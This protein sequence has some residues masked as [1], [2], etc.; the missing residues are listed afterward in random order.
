MAVGDDRPVRVRGPAGRDQPQHRPRASQRRR[1]LDETTS[2][3]GASPASSA[4]ADGIRRLGARPR[5]SSCASTQAAARSGGG[6][7]AGADARPAGAVPPHP[8]RV[9]AA[10]TRVCDSQRFIMGPEVEGMERETGRLP[11]RRPRGRR[12][13]GHRRPA[14]GHDGA[15]HRARRRGHHQHLLVL[16][17]RG[18]R[19]AP[20]RDAGVRRHRPGH[21]QHRSRRRRPPPSRRG[22]KAIIPV[23][24]YGQ[25]ADLDPLLAVAAR[26]GVPVIEDAAQAIGATYKGRL[27]GGI[28]RVGLLL[29]LPQQEPRRVRR[30][31][32]RHHQRRRRWPRRCAACA[33][34]APT[35]STTTR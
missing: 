6:H 34:T 30:R 32:A 3:C 24:L 18:L 35:A 13:V 26:A 1:R 25:S 15:R 9:L 27:V 28:G 21:L 22:R 31:R 2:R 7:H 14:A 33:C 11:G 10:V 23:H 17:H 5:C 16:R 4:T 12:V 19:G 8:R 29:V 20:G